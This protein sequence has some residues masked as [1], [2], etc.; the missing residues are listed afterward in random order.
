M[1]VLGRA[2]II[3]IFVLLAIVLALAMTFLGFPAGYHY[4]FTVTDA[5]AGNSTWS[6]GYVATFFGQIIYTSIQD[7]YTGPSS[8]P[9]PSFP[10]PSPPFAVIAVAFIVNLAI[11]IIFLTIL[12][13]IL[14]AGRRH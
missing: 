13:L 12:W 7:S 9:A 3:S 5:S 6:Q 14:K 8:G 11:A 2:R 10:L 4:I 1:S